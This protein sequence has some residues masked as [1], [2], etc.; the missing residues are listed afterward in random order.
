MLPVTHGALEARR[1]SMVYAVV[2]VAISLSLVLTGAV[3]GVY[4]AIAAASGALFL[5]LAWMQIR[6]ATVKSA[7]TLFKY[8]TSYL[9]IIFLAMVADRLV[10]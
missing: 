2:T 7:M 3:G 8:S 4:L 1:R 5:W 10:L 9:A 6:L